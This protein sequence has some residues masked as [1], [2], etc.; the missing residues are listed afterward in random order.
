MKSTKNTRHGRINTMR[1][2]DIISQLADVIYL[3][4][5]A[6]KSD[7]YIILDHL[8]NIT[9]DELNSLNLLFPDDSD[10]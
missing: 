6:K 8:T 9:E 4:C 3:L 7:I 10:I 2:K 5:R 1:M